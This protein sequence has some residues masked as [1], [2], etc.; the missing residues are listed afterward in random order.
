[1]LISKIQ[2]HLTDLL[3]SARLAIGLLGFVPWSAEKRAMALVPVAGGRQSI[4]RGPGYSAFAAEAHAAV[5]M[6][7][8]PIAQAWPVLN[9]DTTKTG[10][11]GHSQPRGLRPS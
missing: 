3:A 4:I 6:H 11:T 1:M 9:I 8:D 2:S 5:C 10:D 7:A